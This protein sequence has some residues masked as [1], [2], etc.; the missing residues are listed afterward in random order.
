VTLYEAYEVHRECVCMWKNS[1]SENTGFF[2]LSD[3]YVH[4]YTQGR[5]GLDILLDP[6]SLEFIVRVVETK[7]I[8]F[9]I[10]PRILELNV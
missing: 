4:R 5:I 2:I 10:F 9:D 7:K 6:H 8:K 3:P 1:K